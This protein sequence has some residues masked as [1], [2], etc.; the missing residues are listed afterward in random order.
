MTQ[1]LINT[2]IKLS[3]CN[4]CGT[5]VLAAMVG[6][7]RCAADPAPLSRQEVVI[8]LQAGRRPYK[9]VE[10][11]G[12]PWRLDFA[13][14]DTLAGSAKH[15]RAH[16]C[17]CAAMDATAFEEGP[18]DPH[19]APVR[20]GSPRDGSRP[21]HAL[22]GAQTATQ[23]LEAVSTASHPRSDESLRAIRCAECGKLIPQGDTKRFQVEIPLEY[24]RLAKTRSRPGVKSESSLVNEVGPLYWAVHSDGCTDG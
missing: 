5:Y 20:H 3:T 13:T 12:K 24:T 14:V 19:Q 15:L 18:V 11:C 10:Q 21:P 6:G 23:G 17:G 7:V 4:R 1:H 9:L 22:A 8:D 16:G 2:K